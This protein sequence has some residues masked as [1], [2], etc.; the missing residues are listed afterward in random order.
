M[1]RLVV[2]GIISLMI[3]GCATL[4]QQ[5]VLLPAM[6][7]AW[8]GIHQDIEMAIEFLPEADQPVAQAGLEAFDRAFRTG[9]LDGAMSR[10]TTLAELCMDGIA[11]R[12]EIGEIGPGVAESKLERLRMFRRA[13][14][15][16]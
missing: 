10:W 8:D 16:L 9:D 11:H 13:M 5:N 12:V 6:E 14:E 3:L 2:V 7:K 4:A 15:E 1:K